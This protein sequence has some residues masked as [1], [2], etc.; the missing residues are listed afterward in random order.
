MMRWLWIQPRSSSFAIMFKAF[1]LLIIT[2]NL[3]IIS[4]FFIFLRNQPKAPE[5]TMESV[6][7]SCKSEWRT[8]EEALIG[9]TFANRLRNACTVRK[10]NYNA[11]T[12][13]IALAWISNSKIC[14]QI[15]CFSSSSSI[16]EMTCY[17]LLRIDRQLLLVSDRNSKLAQ[18]SSVSQ[19]C[20]LRALCSTRFAF[21]KKFEQ[22]IAR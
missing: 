22:C 14:I 3:Y 21:V 2:I 5:S 12:H 9:T 11:Q 8:S 13:W 19:H 10:I 4:I 20:F 7:S 15:G 1:Y 16:F 17:D 6:A 18:S